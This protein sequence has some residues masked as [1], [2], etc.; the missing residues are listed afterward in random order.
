MVNNNIQVQ[1]QEIPIVS[2]LDVENDTWGQLKIMWV[3][4]KI[5]GKLLFS[6]TLNSF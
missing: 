6:A 4:Q 3:N 1:V 2:K 5:E